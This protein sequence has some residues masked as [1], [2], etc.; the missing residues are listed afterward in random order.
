MNV[1]IIYAVVKNLHKLLIALYCNAGCVCCSNESSCC[2]DDC[3]FQQT[4]WTTGHFC[5]RINRRHA[6]DQDRDSQNSGTF[7]LFSKWHSVLSLLHTTVP[8]SIKIRQHLLLG[9]FCL[10]LSHLSISFKVLPLAQ[11]NRFLES[12]FIIVFIFTKFHQNQSSFIFWHNMSFWHFWSFTAGTNEQTLYCF[13]ILLVL[14]LLSD[15][16]VFRFLFIYIN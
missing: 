9:T 12:F 11:M 7:I 4:T 16:V 10:L 6:I 15:W 1:N 2:R 3:Q 13:E 14:L 8:R 5:Q